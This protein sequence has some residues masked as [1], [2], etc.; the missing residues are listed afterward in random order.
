[1]N[2]L[3]F[4][5]YVQHIMAKLN[6]DT[7]TL[8][9]P[10]TGDTLRTAMTKVNT[11][12]DDIYSLVGDGS[13]G[14]ITTSFTNGDLKL[15]A[16]GTGAIEIDNLQIINSAITS[17][18]TNSDVTI[19]GNGTGGVNVGSVTINDNELSASN[20]N[21]DLVLSGSG[22][23]AVVIQ[24]LTVN[25][26]SISSADSTTINFNDNV[27]VDGTLTVTGSLNFSDANI[28][29]VGTLALDKIFGDGD[30]NTSIAFSGSDV[31]TIETGGSGRLT[32]G[33]GALSPVTDNQIDL[34]TSSLEFKDAFF[35]GTV[36]TDALTVSG[37]STFNGAAMG[38]AAITGVADP[39]NAQDAA[40]KAYVDAT[41]TAQDL[42]V[43]SDSGTAAV[44]LDSQSLTVTGGTG[45]GTTAT[46]QA[47][48]VNIDATVATLAGSQT[49]TNKTIDA[50]GTGNNI[51]NIDIGNM[52]AASVVLEAEGIASN[53][54]D[55]TLPTSAAVKDYADTKAVLT[56]STNNTIA[57]VTGAH[58]LNGEANLTFDGSTLAVT[59]AAT[60]NSTVTAATGSIFGN[61]TLADGSITDS[62]GAISFGN[63]NLTTTGTISAETGSTLGNLTLADGSITDSSGAI[64][65]GNENLS[66]TGTLT[67][68]DAQISY[69]TSSTSSSSTANMDTFASATFRSAKYQVQIV[70]ATN[71]KF[72]IYELFVTHDGSAAYINSQGI[73]DTGVDLAT[74]TADIDSGSVRI[75]VVP[76]S[77]DGIVFK[78]IRTTFTV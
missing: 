15:Q 43:A 46:G 40:T 37:T 11:N 64:S 23:G 75:R 28:S 30:T 26:T 63:E 6:I 76:I 72:G 36:T 61:L 17:I 41:V 58:A 56:G 65:F 19:S 24:A 73:S 78:F 55:T 34:G 2:I 68:T 1:M 5:K 54:N 3:V 14:L 38:S 74:F 4:N 60:F 50:N 35:D 31:I 71:T 67:F 27:R 29:D 47:L 42:D 66:T 32:I 13:T 69:G 21:D 44:D 20:S 22:T 59:G 45:I 70:D 49:F 53:D 48:T 7:G 33:D 77:A 25:G 10:A 51:S 39:S 9:N 62:S 52:T 12:F 8:G 16:N 57:T 18:T